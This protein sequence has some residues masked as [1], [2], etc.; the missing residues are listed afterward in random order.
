MSG[1]GG[2]GVDAS[3]DASLILLCREEFTDTLVAE[4]RR[5]AG[6]RQV[7]LGDADFAVEPGWV[8]VTGPQAVAA[9]AALDRPCI[10]ERQRLERAE[11]VANAGLK[12]MA[13]EVIVR[14]L[15]AISRRNTPWT[16]HVFAP[17]AAALIAL[18]PRATK[19]EEVFLAACRERF[20]AVFRRYVPPRQPDLPPDLPVLQLCVTPAGVWGSVMP[21]SR[22]SD[23]AVG[24]IHRMA[25][26]DLAPSRSYL[27]I[28]EVLHLLAEKPQPGQ[29]VVDLGAAP[30][31][32][33]YAFLKR[34]CAVTAVDNGELKLKSLGERGGQLM[35]RR[36][37]GITFS[38]DPARVPVDWL[39][40]DM[41][42][43]SGKN[44]G[45]MRRW[46]DHRWM[47]QFAINLKLPQQAPD[48]VLVPI[49]D[50]LATVPDLWFRIRQLY[51][52]RREVTLFGRLGHP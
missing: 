13:R 2:T 16:A 1:D 38:P 14:L 32:W 33:T 29:T 20:S 43:P 45:M 50:Y 21:R 15:P 9:T 44:L 39:V 40:S 4:V 18:S 19:F 11:L 30:G 23:P 8:R 12:P 34:G 49:E 6:L 46:F 17:A 22:L 24:G 26:D 25:F 35:H 5:R 42:V 27:K 37:D 52:D 47:R 28:E 36:E 10:F 3:P 48:A 51:H 7:A 41:L 31:G